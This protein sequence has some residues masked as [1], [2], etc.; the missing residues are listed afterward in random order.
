MGTMLSSKLRES[1]PGFLQHWCPGCRQR[2]EIAVRPVVNSSGAGWTWNG[3][4]ASP[5]FTP[6]VHI[7]VGPWDDEDG[8]HPRTTV[9]HYFVTGGQI[10]YLAD[11]AHDLKGQTI[12]LPDWPEGRT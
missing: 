4:V 11:C 7:T 10:Q 1:R 8:H 2:H 3:S 12:E 5:T 6:S 9:C